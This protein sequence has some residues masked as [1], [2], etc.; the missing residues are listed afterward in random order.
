MFASVREAAAC[1]R[2]AIALTFALLAPLLMLCMVGAIDLTQLMATENHLQESTDAAALAVSATTSETP[3]SSTSSL[4]TLANTMLDAN[5]GDATPTLSNFHVCTALTAD[6]VTDAGTVMQVNTVTLTTSVRAPCYFPL[7]LPGVCTSAG[8]SH[9]LTASNI[10]NI[11]IPSNIQ[12]NMLLDVSG[13]MIVGSTPAD[14]Q[15]VVNWNNIAANWNSIRDTGDSNQNTPCAFACHDHHS[16]NSTSYNSATSDMQAGLNNAHLAPQSASSTGYA[17]TRFDV[18]IQAA[19]NLITH[20]K[21]EVGANSQ[22]AK[23]SYYMNVSSVADNLTQNFQAVTANDWTDPAN[24]INKLYVGLDTHLN[25]NLPTF[26]SNVGASGNGA[27]AATPLKFALLVTDGLQ[28]DFYS[29]FSCAGAQAD[30][31]WDVPGY[32]GSNSV[33][34]YWQGYYATGCYA[35]AMATTACT[36]L[37]NNGVIVGVLE[38]PYV[39][40]NGQDPGEYSLY[41]TFVRHTI[42]P[43]GPG[44]ASTVSAALQACASPG[45]Y[46]QASS[47]DPTSISSGFVTLTD[48]FL[49]ST[50]FIRK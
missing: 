35:S 1:R 12:I 44:T 37:K 28:S 48:K 4:K 23:N 47:S 6:C 16:S 26:A 24:A 13:S 5:Y 22:L 3:T 45:Y 46:Y 20:V 2:G 50:A 21:T 14:V 29:D 42:Y 17:V 38:T 31:A 27:T 25:Q 30:T 7:I 32:Y 34:P 10:S 43:T 8:Q 11:G 15:A 9:I 36:T 40:L 39:P 33:S 19:S 49:A 41:E 18:M